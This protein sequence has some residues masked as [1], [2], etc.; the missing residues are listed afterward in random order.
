MWPTFSENLTQNVFYC[1]VTLHNDFCRTFCFRKK[2]LFV[3]LNPRMTEKVLHNIELYVLSISMRCTCVKRFPSHQAQTHDPEVGSF[4]Q[5][6]EGL[7]TRGR[8][9]S[10][11]P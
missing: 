5:N 4:F 11:L 9:K 3:C 8:D 10:L 2:K 1:I 6:S 7:S